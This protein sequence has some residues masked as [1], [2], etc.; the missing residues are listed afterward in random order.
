MSFLLLLYFDAH[1][2]ELCMCR[3]WNKKALF[4]F[5]Y[6]HPLREV[7]LSLRHVRTV[8]AWFVTSQL[9]SKPILVQYVTYTSVM[10][11]LE[12]TYSEKWTFQWSRRHLVSCSLT[13]EMNNI[14]IF[15]DSGLFNEWEGTDVILRLF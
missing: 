13:S 11:K 12:G 3:V 1:C 6:I 4:T 14:G 15:I 7:N 2:A 5:H 9:V 8:K 10:W